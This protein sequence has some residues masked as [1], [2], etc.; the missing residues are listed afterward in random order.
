MELSFLHQSENIPE[1]VWPWGANQAI[2]LR[3]FLPTKGHADNISPYQ[4]LNPNAPPVNMSWAKVMYS[5]CTVVCSANPN[6]VHSKLGQ[7]GY[8]AC[9]LGY[10]HKRH[11]Y[12]LW[13]KD[14]KRISTFRSVTSWRPKEFTLVK[15]ITNDLP[16]QYFETGDLPL[17]P[18]TSNS[19]QKTFR[20]VAPPNVP[21][22]NA[23]APIPAW[24]PP[25]G[26]EVVDTVASRDELDGPTWRTN[27][28]ESR[29][30]LLSTSENYNPILKSKVP[31]AGSTKLMNRG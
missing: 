7:R 16:V 19:M 1:C 5:D 8:D 24:A 23:A 27:I 20:S 11:G 13:V 9:H 4:F 31:S 17:S 3:R 25:P 29:E 18:V 26:Y 28:I 21:A 2:N 14:L 10:D 30:S 6:D 22:P 12:I 15:Y